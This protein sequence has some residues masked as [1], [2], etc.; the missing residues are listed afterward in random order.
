MLYCF[1]LE[2]RSQ[3]MHLDK[4]I[5]VFCF[6]M[7]LVFFDSARKDKYLWD[8][9]HY[10]P[11]HVCVLFDD[12]GDICV[13]SLGRFKNVFDIQHHTTHNFNWPRIAG[14]RPL[15]HF[16]DTTNVSWWI[17]F[18]CHVQAVYQ[19]VPTHCCHQ[20]LICNRCL[21]AIFKN[22]PS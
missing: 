20:N 13:H 12:A 15:L 2:T 19:H 3:V 4:I 9:F 5:I 1:I 18:G 10:L 8:N 6:W 16:T 11:L 22:W 21:A 7:F 17:C 14:N